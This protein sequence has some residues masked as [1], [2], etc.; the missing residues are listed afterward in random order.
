M[1]D[2]DSNWILAR[3]FAID[4]F[5]QIAVSKSF[6]VRLL[7]LAIHPILAGHLGQQ[8]MYDAVELRSYRSYMANFMY[9]TANDCQ[10]HAKRIAKMKYQRHLTLFLPIGQLEFIVVDILGQLLRSK[11]RN[12]SGVIITD[13]YSELA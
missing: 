13:R 5:I 10:R 8:R 1:F 9:R 3:H 11:N 6:P 4:D 2:I 12:Q 7:Y